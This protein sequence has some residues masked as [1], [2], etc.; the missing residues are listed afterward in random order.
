MQL[1]AASHTGNFVDGKDEREKISESNWIEQNQTFFS[2]IN[3]T[4]VLKMTSAA[5]GLDM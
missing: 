5:F 1:L 4:Q 3:S 2:T